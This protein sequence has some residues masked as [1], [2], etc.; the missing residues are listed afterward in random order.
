[1]CNPNSQD[2]DND[3]HLLAMECALAWLKVGQLPLEATGQIY[4]HLLA[5]AAYY[6][7]SRYNIDIYMYIYIY[8]N[9]K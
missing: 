5:A 2:I 3:M 4:S 8:D 6:A 7:P 1:M 9:N